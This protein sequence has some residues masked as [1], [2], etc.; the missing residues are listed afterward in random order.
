M[1]V[2]RDFI[3]QM[4]ISTEFLMQGMLAVSAVH[5]AHLQPQ[6][7]LELLRRASISEHAA[8][9]A[10]RKAV[11]VQDQKTVHAALAFG[12]FV[13]QYVLAL[14]KNE[15]GKIPKLGD[16]APHWFHLIR[17][18][19]KLT[20]STWPSL[21]GGPFRPLLTYRTYPVIPEDN[22][23]DIHLAQ[24]YNMLGESV[25]SSHVDE[26]ALATCRVALDEL[27]RVAATPYTARSP[28]DAMAVVYIWPGT[29][30]EDYIML[31][32]QRR[33]EALVILAHYCVLLKKIDSCWYTGGIGRNLLAACEMT[34]GTEWAP[35]IQWA[36]DQPTR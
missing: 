1:M 10:F 18:L 5:L 32:H 3:P 14:S 27:R 21:M 16:S 36:V 9:P 20:I 24:L 15:P 26:E 25:P 13:V 2:W 8:L 4:A 22:P 19:V 29:V 33:P 28:L 35:W 17:G 7:R 34:L 12:G 11:S 23:E 31:L 6:R 30:Q